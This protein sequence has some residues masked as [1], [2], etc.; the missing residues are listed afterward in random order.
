MTL[1][2]KV[3]V[4]N[5]WNEYQDE[6]DRLATMRLAISTSTELEI[7]IQL[8]L[9]EKLLQKWMDSTDLFQST[10]N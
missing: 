4:D 5:S 3:D 7:Q 2:S 1:P 10:L 8:D 6:C 9:T